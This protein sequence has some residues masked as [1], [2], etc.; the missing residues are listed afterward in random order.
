[1]LDSLCIV[2]NQLAI[3]IKVMTFGCCISPRNVFSKKCAALS[4][5]SD[6]STPYLVSLEFL[7]AGTGRF[8]Q[9]LWLSCSK[10][11]CFEESCLYVGASNSAILDLL[12][13]G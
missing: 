12:H 13:C 4:S 8:L 11:C 2:G 7:H 3:C 6:I 1:M 10:A 5:K 9:K